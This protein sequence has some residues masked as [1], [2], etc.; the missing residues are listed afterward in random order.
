MESWS[1]TKRGVCENIHPVSQPATQTT[2]KPDGWEIN[3]MEGSM[4]SYFDS[5][6]LQM[7]PAREHRSS[8][9]KTRQISLMGFFY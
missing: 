6:S 1:S 3:W 7:Q 8:F 4:A 2:I 9:S 5:L